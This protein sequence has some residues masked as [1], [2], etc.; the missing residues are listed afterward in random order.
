MPGTQAK[1]GRRTPECQR[2]EP[3]RSSSTQALLGLTHTLKCAGTHS[4]SWPSLPRVGLD[5]IPSAECQIRQGREHLSAREYVLRTGLCEDLLGSGNV[6]Q[7][8]NTVAIGFKSRGIGLGGGVKQCVSGIALAKGGIQVRIGR[9]D[10]VFDL[11]A[12]SADLCFGSPD[13]GFRLRQPAFSRSSVKH[14]PAQ[15]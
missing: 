13:L 14:G 4:C 9:P 1:P 5:R 3:V 2:K 11:I 10:L 6:Q 8:T 15:A 12:R 7:V